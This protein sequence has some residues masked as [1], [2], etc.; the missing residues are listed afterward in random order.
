MICELDHL[1]A[2]N[3]ALHASD[4]R[5]QT[6]LQNRFVALMTAWHHDM[7]DLSSPALAQALLRFDALAKPFG[8]TRQAIIQECTAAINIARGRSDAEA[9]LPL[10]L[11]SLAM[12]EFDIG[13]VP[14]TTWAMWQALL[15][16]WPGGPKKVWLHAELARRLINNGF[17]DEEAIRVIDDGLALLQTQSPWG[18]DV[19]SA[20]AADR[21]LEITMRERPEAGSWFDCRGQLLL[22]RGFAETEAGKLQAAF[23]SL[24]LA[25]DDLEATGNLQRRTNADHNLAKV[26]L[27]LGHL[28]ECIAVATKACEAYASA[29]W[30][31]GPDS[32]GVTAMQKLIAAACLQLGSPNDLLRAYTVLQVEQMPW[33]DNP[34]RETNADAYAIGAEVLLARG[35]RSEPEEE[36]FTATLA[37]LREFCEARHLT[38]LMVQADLLDAKHS[39]QAGDLATARAFAAKARAGSAHCEDKIWQIRSH[40][41]CAGVALRSNAPAAA[42]RDFRAAGEALWAEV[43]AE[44][45]WRI[46][47][48]ITTFER[49][50]DDVLRGAFEAY[51][52]IS[53]TDPAALTDLYD[54]VQRFHGGQSTFALSGIGF[55]PDESLLNAEERRKLEAARARRCELLD[56]DARFRRAPPSGYFSRK[57]ASDAAEDRKKEIR[58]ID[59]S[60]RTTRQA[61]PV[62]ALRRVASLADVQAALSE[63]ELLLECVELPSQTVAFAIRRGGARLFAFSNQGNPGNLEEALRTHSFEACGTILKAVRELDDP[64]ISTLLYSPEGRLCYSPIAAFPYAGGVLAQRAAVVRTISGSA[65]VIARKARHTEQPPRNYLALANPRYSQTAVRL[66]EE[67]GVVGQAVARG[68]AFEPLPS[69]AREVVDVAK[70]FAD[71]AELTK[72]PRDPASFNGEIEGRRFRVL[73]GSS[74]TEQALTHADLQG[75]GVL[76]F[77]CHGVAD[78]SAPML[79]FLALAIV[80]DGGPDGLDNGLLRMGELSRLHGD[81]QLV[82]LSACETSAGAVR[83]H[84]GPACLALAAQAAGARRV[85]S[86]LWRVGDDTTREFVTEFCTAMFRDGAP[87]GLALQRAQSKVREG[88]SKDWAAFVLWGE[89]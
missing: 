79:S 83:G 58:E 44:Q 5:A 6:E 53:G 64:A 12:W 70:T 38:D 85:L 8:V 86:T 17:R 59:R 39:L 40:V 46:E 63:D 89:P 50:H 7:G 41:V 37:A 82:I 36:Q 25:S 34:L 42:L 27:G 52:R 28:E 84:D 11:R 10:L 33:P 87:A 68:G 21:D 80:D 23:A 73:L 66:R 15:T 76:H 3:Q 49:I 57:I 61:L 14:E 65:F 69:T 9:G 1:I 55:A 75:V 56:D 71:P 72:F 4:V 30:R 54:I 88:G 19:G 35:S 20:L 31:N 48:G 16:R 74:A 47:G 13:P 29:T 62:P 51:E 77:A 22:L 60:I 81:Y 24:Q 78:S 32:N 18:A 45:L 26:L 43:E 67:A 2:A